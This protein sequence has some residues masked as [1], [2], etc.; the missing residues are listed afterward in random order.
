MLISGSNMG[1]AFTN[2]GPTVPIVVYYLKWVPYMCVTEQNQPK[3]VL[4]FPASHARIEAGT[5]STLFVNFNHKVLY[6]VCLLI[7]FL[8]WRCHGCVLTDEFEC[9]GIFNIS[10]EVN[11]CQL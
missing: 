9:L 6:T 7:M 8:P 1:A 11:P 2:R 4:Q 5:L 10:F 3:K